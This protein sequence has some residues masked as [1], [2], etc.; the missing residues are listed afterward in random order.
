MTSKQKL[1]LIAFLSI[2][3]NLMLVNIV[4]AVPFAFIT[5]NGL[6]SHDGSITIIDTGVQPNTI[7]S[8]VMGL[9]HNLA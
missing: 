1:Y 5:N 2:A 3:M 6:S 7:T 4:G 8:K 9:K